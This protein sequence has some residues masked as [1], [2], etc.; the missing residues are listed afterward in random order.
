[1]KKLIV[2]FVALFVSAMASISVLKSTSKFDD[3]IF[4]SNV[5]ALARS[6]IGES[7]CTGP[8]KE[9]IAGNIFCHCENTAPCKDMYGCN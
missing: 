4:E 6:E 8:K 5:E 1:M 2:S 7:S 9:N 3:S